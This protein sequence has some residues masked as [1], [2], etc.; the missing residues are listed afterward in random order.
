MQIVCP[1]FG[2]SGDT[3]RGSGLTRSS[4]LPLALPCHRQ[5]SKRESELQS[6][7]AVGEDIP[8]FTWQGGFDYSS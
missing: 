4:F 3:S 1:G 8:L 5:E 7:R 2:S 6:H